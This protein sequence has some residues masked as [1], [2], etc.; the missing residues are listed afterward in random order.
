MKYIFFLCFGFAKRV[1]LNRFY[2]LLPPSTTF[3]P[4]SP[5][6]PSHILNPPNQI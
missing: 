1:K 6:P 3:S 2:H 4:Y 5:S